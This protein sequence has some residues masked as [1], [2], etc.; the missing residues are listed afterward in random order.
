M[1]LPAKP[2]NH[3]LLGLLMVA[4]I[5]P[6]LIAGAHKDQRKSKEHGG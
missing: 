5:I 4:G 2:F 1:F 6:S 3:G